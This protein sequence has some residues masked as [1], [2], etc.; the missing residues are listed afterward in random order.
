MARPSADEISRAIVIWTGYML[1]PTPSRADD[2]VVT[3][4]GTE[5]AL[6]LLPLVHRLQKEFYESDAYN[7]VA[8]LDAMG[9]AAAA[10]FRGRH[11]EL[12]D[13]AVEALA[14]CYTYDWK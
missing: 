13:A 2:L 1:E 7:T 14:W 9:N 5:A 11:P 4:L 10:D 3:M 6:D 8:D 12:R